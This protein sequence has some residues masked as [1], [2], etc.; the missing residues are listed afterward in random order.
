MRDIREMG[1]ATQGVK[2]IKT[3]GGD[4]KVTSVAK[5]QKTAEGEEVDE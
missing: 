1:R 3:S 4:D 5:V 2:I